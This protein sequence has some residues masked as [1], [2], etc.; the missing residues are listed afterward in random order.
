MRSIGRWWRELL[1]YGGVVLL[2]ALL[3]QGWALG[4]WLLERTWQR[5]WAELQLQLFCPTEELALELRHWLS[6]E[7]L[8]A[9]LRQIPPQQG[10]SE[11]QRWLGI[12]A[13]LPEVPDSLLPSVL[14]VRLR[15]EE[16]DRIAA[17]LERVRHRSS[18]AEL[19]FPLEQA[20]Q[21]W[22]FRTVGQWGWGAVGAVMAALL[23]MLLWATV[24]RM[25]A[26]V[27]AY[28][29]LVLLGIAPLRVW[30]PLGAALGVL[31]IGVAAG[32][33]G[34]TLWGASRMHVLEGVAWGT[35]LPRELLA[36]SALPGCWSAAAALVGI[37]RLR[38]AL[39][40]R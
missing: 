13:E 28:Q 14:I 5:L 31:S 27:R 11:L 21:L 19:H 2:G 1:R 24:S 15:M 10:W 17:L 18:G 29:V 4:W 23:G 3:L 39:Y 33:V 16:P 20:Q 9:E 38:R 30:G 6:A 35:A 26:R 37:L 12:G 22:W 36:V 40:H 8:V 32:V 25:Q 7:P 34:A